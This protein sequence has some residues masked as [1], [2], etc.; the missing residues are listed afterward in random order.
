MSASFDKQ[1]ELLL[2]QAYGI[3]SIPDDLNF[4]PRLVIEGKQHEFAPSQD[5][6]IV[7]PDEKIL[8]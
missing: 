3:N 5:E 8:I 6:A 2:R 1:Q 4:K 7:D